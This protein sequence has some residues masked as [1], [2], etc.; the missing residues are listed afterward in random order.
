MAK[1][2]K[3][4]WLVAGVIV[5]LVAAGI[6]VGSLGSSSSSESSLLTG[7]GYPN[8]DTSNTRYVGG[9]IDSG[10]VSKLQSAWTLPLSAKSQYGSYSSSPIISN[11]AVFSQDLGLQCAGDQPEDRQGDSGRKPT[12]PRIRDRTAWSSRVARCS[13]RRR[14]RRSR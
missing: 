12:N 14:R 11:G 5:V 4:A 9:P 8:G 3:A 13:E 2:P 1:A 7:S 10:T 6:A